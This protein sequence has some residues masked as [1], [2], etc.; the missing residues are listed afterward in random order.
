MLISIVNLSHGALADEELQRVIRAI[1]RQIAEDF[2]P[3]W[4]FGAT[5]RLEGAVGVRPRQKTLSEMRGDALIY[6]W[7]K[8][9]VEDALGYHDR[10]D[11]GIPYGIVSL[12]ECRKAG[13]NWTSTL[14][15]E[16]LELLGDPESNL[17]V[18][19]PH[20]GDKRRVVFH[21]FEMC[22]AV[23]GEYYEIAGVQLS[24]FILPAYFTRGEQP[25]S[26]NDFLARAYEGRVLQ[27][28]GINPGGYL[29]F[30]DP[31]KK[32]DTTFAHKDDVQA[33]AV[34]ARKDAAKLGRGW[35]RRHNAYR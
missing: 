24:N 2:E 28:F 9:D 26:R 7:D 4:S 34:L 30:Y 17:L 20:P 16:A 21:W 11:N 1:N 6:V 35:R 33:K 19:G 14:S 18:R 5:L 29:G 27:S 23:Q 31:E 22:D 10:N 3:Y 8:I 13:D 25:G 15:H 12:N 32:T